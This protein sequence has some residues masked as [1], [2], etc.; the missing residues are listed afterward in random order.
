MTSQFDCGGSSGAYLH[1]GATAPGSPADGALWFNPQPPPGALQRWDEAGN[2]WIMLG[3]G[4]G[5]AGIQVS[6]TD[7]GAASKPDGAGWLDPTTG[8]LKFAS[9][10]VWID[11]V[12]PHDITVLGVP[13]HK[14]INAAA[15]AVANNQAD[16]VFA[17]G[18]ADVAHSLTV[19]Y[20]VDGGAPQTKTATVDVGETSDIAANKLVAAITGDIVA[21]KTG[22][23]T[24]RV[25]VGT[26]RTLDSLQITV[27]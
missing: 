13:K 9:G 17:G 20:G 5:G 1:I 26:A 10:G 15:G 21:K 6:T 8:E 2:Q 25:T 23:G 24:L 11:A 18:P 22:V 12:D 16:I 7:P 3:L 14:D 27:A 19:A 4:G